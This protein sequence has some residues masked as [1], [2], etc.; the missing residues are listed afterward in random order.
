[1]NPSVAARIG[2][3]AIIRVAAALV[4]GHGADVAARVFETAGLA[5]YLRD[6]PGIMVDE[7]EVTRLQHALR[8]YLG[9]AAAAAVSREAGRLTAEYLLAHRIPRAV[10]RLLAI[11]PPRAASRVLLAA[12]SRHAWTF[13]G[14]GRFGVEHGDVLVLSITG[15]AVCR[16]AHGDVPLCDYYT[17]TFERLFRAL[18]ARSASVTEVACEGA[19]ATCCRFEVRW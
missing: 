16:G 8:A 11:L 12:I 17:A 14:S 1:M 10:Q 18:V 19:G 13:A 3:N 15:C 7:D 6:A 9:D 4:D 2:P 5:A